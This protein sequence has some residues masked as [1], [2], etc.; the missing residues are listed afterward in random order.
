M[1]EELRNLL[2][3]E[4]PFVSTCTAAA[5]RMLGPE[6]LDWDPLVIR[7]S[8]QDFIGISKLPQKLFDKINCGYTLIGTNGY[9]ASIETL[10]S[11]NSVMSSIPFEEGILPLDDQYT[12]AWGAWE[13]F[14]L[15][16]DTPETV[17][18]SVDSSIYAGEV[19]YRAGI[20][21]PPSWLSWVSYDPEKIERLSSLLDD[22]QFYMDRQNGL[23]AELENHCKEKDAQLVLQLER[24][25]KLIKAPNQ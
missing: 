3:K 19:L 2:I 10:I 13:Y 9:T 22:P 17:T 18:F 12:L 11:C 23:K 1:K 25:D 6:S 8:V 15:T 7:D 14:R 21:N 16:G 20:T 24:L 5:L 4:N